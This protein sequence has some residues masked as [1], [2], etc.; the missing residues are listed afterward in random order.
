[1][2]NV[3]IALGAGIAGFVLMSFLLGFGDF[4]PLYGLMPGMLIAA[5]AYIWLARR[6]MTKVQKIM[7]EAQHHLQSA[8]QPTSP[9]DIQ[10]AQRSTEEA[11][12]ILKRA[13]PYNKWQFLVESQVNG[14]IGQIYYMTKKFEQ[15]EPYLK[16]SFN[17]NW[18]A[19]T[20][21]ACLYYQRKEW[22]VMTETFEV[23][24]KYS[25]KEALMW[26]VY[27]W[28]LWKAGK[29]D[30]AIAVLTRALEHVGTDEQTR[31]NRTALQNKKNMK[32]REWNLMWY[33][34]HL[35][36]PPQPKPGQQQPVPQINFR[37]R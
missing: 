33:Q 19:Q 1:M 29:T 14:Q 4:K 18:I 17:R 34:F 21:L 30:D 9:A 36:A 27:A 35:D 26:N 20:M 22:A 23:A 7:E 10:K 15:A 11:V 13:L 5:G 3:L 32:M 6:V 12:E 8:P 25:P 24:A 37:R 28:C 16:G 2:Y 31:E